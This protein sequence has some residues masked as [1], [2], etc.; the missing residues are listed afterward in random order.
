MVTDLL[1]SH[2]FHAEAVSRLL[3]RSVDRMVVFYTVA[4]VSRVYS[5]S[6]RCVF[7]P[8]NPLTHPRRD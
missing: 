7:V 3:G 2:Q 1:L 4:S 6:V 5:V 8:Y